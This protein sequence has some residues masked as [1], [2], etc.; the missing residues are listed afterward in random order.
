MKNSILTIVVIF[1]LLVA[2]EC[3]SDA[4]GNSSE[5]IQAVSLLGKQLI[6]AVP[7]E[8][9]IAKWQE[10]KQNYKTDPLNAENIIWY[11]R[12]TAYAGDYR[13]A[14]SIFTQGIKDFP[15]DAR[16]YRHRGHRY[17]S[18]RE[19][20]LAVADFEKASKL[21]EGT[22][23]QVEPD[24]IPN[25][26]NTP[27]STLHSNIRYH[28]GLAYY[29]KNDLEKALAVYKK[30]LASTPN[31]DML[32]ATTHW[33]YMTLR[34][35]GREEE[36]RALLVPIT[37]EM[38]VIENAAYHQLCLLYKGI[39]SEEE[40]MA[41]GGEI[42]GF[43]NDA[44]LYGLGNW[45][46]YNDRKERA[47]TIFEQILGGGIW[48]AFGYIAAEAD[49]VRTFQEKTLIGTPIRTPEW[50]SETKAR[51]EKD[52]EIAQAVFKVAP[53]R[54]DSYI[55]LGRRYGYLA[56]Y[57]EAIKVF[58][59]GLEKFPESYKLYRFR[60]RHRIRS[61]EFEA[62]IADYQRAAELA[63]RH[64]DT[65]EP[66]GIANSI[67]QPLETYKSNIYYY[68]GQ[69][70]FAL[71]EYKALI[72]NMEKAAT[73]PLAMKDSELIAPIAFWK[74]LAY[75]NLGEHETARQVVEA[76]PDDLEL[77]QEH[78]YHS[79]VLFFKGER[80]AEQIYN[81]KDMLIRFAIAMEHLFADDLD[82][83]RTMLLAIVKDSPL[84]FWPAEVE[85][86]KFRKSD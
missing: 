86:M 27:I 77:Y 69:S 21:I 61:R 65:F 44:L 64:P 38:N 36:A 39:I 53:E 70:H 84:G 74:Y 35:L 6:S 31:D 9:T 19:F 81:E 7:S 47:K 51:L 42:T 78:S 68:M 12:R 34:K 13:G 30:D 54:E 26:L 41:E 33:T 5:N 22:N 45:H 2:T 49:Y 46:F 50:T 16:F 29:L 11:G 76:V 85:L 72:R 20:D 59:A 55:W 71:G 10:A 80:N 1:N 48:A 82:I 24:G 3:V 15:E 40:L 23:D 75:R 17:I 4:T 57:K 14:I 37:K 60:A 56:E 28:L 32:V 79:A 66:N 8:S 63:E 58:T 83:A 67:E 18:V 62:G 43:M 25:A 73:F 52:L